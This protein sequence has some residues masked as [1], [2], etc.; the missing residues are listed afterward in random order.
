[1]H[2]L[3]P[4]AS[5]LSPACQAAL[6]TLELP[7]LRA[8]LARMTPGER[9]EGDEYSL[10]APHERAPARA[11]G[12]TG[13]DGALPW[14]ARQ[15]G[16]DGVATGDLAWGLLTPV[17][18]HVGSDHLSVVNPDALALGEADSRA[19]FDAVRALFETEG[20]A[21]VW[22]APLRWYVAHESLT[23]LP[24]ASL[25]RV[26]GRNPD[27]WMPDAP[28][29]R[30]LRRLFA[31]V[32]MCFYAHPLHDA[33]VA[34]GLDPVNSVW[35]SGCGVQ[36]AA[37]GEAP[38]VLDALRAP[39]L[40]EDWPRWMQAWQALD[41]GALREALDRVGR[42]EPL[43]LSLCGERHVQ[44]WRTTSGGWLKTLRARWRAPD[45]ASLLIDL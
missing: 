41:A 19:L 25:D 1:M 37:S 29:A 10:S 11:L 2:L 6:R 24:T 22:G 16:A 43:T 45:P 40:D 30:T 21:L 35:L 18:W 5:G 32:Q 13:A 33:R 39:L 8:L 27:L 15:A 12:L 26:I 14:G 36:Q 7:T 42:G 3:I 28:Q 31:E 17:H 9:D 20:Y 38:L 44:P 23:E 34:G 4:H